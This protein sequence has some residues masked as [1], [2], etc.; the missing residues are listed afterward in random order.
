MPKM[1][2]DCGFNRETTL[3]LDVE[4]VGC[5]A[6][7]IQCQECGGT[8]NWGPFYPDPVDW[9]DCVVCKGTGRQFVSI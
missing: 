5:G 3:L 6:G 9:E 2:V 7:V 4:D 1:A 8:G